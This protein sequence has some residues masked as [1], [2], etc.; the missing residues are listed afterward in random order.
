MNIRIE[1]KSLGEN[2]KRRRK[3]S[4]NSKENRFFKKCKPTTSHIKNWGIKGK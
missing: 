1:K 2:K 4:R 3:D